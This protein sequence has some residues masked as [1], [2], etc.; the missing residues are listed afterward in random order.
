MT[1]SNQ[2]FARPFKCMAIPIEN[3]KPILESELLK[4]EKK[5]NVHKRGACI[6]DKKCMWIPED[7]YGSYRTS[8][9]KSITHLKIESP[10]E[11]LKKTWSQKVYE[12]PENWD[13]NKA[14]SG[15]P[16]IILVNFTSFTSSICLQ[17]HLE[18]PI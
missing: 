2:K 9:T 11:D 12:M 7:E 18:Y 6:N 1:T 13:P 10:S 16:T 17:F 4:I 14:L 3:E 15:T 8:W 5:C